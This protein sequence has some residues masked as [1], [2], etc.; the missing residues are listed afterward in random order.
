MSKN[1]R[2]FSPDQKALIVRRHLSG[3]VPDFGID[4]EAGAQAARRRTSR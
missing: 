1:R 4:F 3:K 2:L